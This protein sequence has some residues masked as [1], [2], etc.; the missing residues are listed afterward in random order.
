MKIA[1][2]VEGQTELIFVRE[3]LLKKHNYRIAVECRTLFSDSD[4]KETKYDFPNDE[5]DVHISIINVGNDVAVLSR[6]K[7]RENHMWESGY[8]KIIGLRDMY[9]K[10]YKE[11]SKVINDEVTR[12]FV[13]GYN[14]QIGKMTKPEN[15][16]FYFAIMEIEAWF[17]ALPLLL[18][19]IDKRLTLEF[20]FEK[21][22]IELDKIDPEKYFFKPANNLNEIYTLVG[23]KYKKSEDIVENILSKLDK[24]DFFSLNE[25]TKCNSF[26]EFYNEI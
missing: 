8:D 3:Y 10:A 6:I 7:K 25:I 23:L 13:D 2:F 5:S 14:E 22:K 19:K 21:L 11:E 17:L 9:S 26:S 1:I 16:K 12:K 18:Q 4:Y 24:N 15:I 20:I